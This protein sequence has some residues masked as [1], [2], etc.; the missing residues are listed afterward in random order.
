MGCCNIGGSNDSNEKL[1]VLDSDFQQASKYK[2]SRFSMKSKAKSIINIEKNACENKHIEK[3]SSNLS[4][5][6]ERMKEGNLT[7]NFD[8][9]ININSPNQTKSSLKQFS[10]L[11]SYNFDD[12]KDFLNQSKYTLNLETIN[13]SSHIKSKS[14]MYVNK[15]NYK[16]FDYNNKVSRLNEENNKGISEVG[17]IM[18]N[19]KNYNCTN[20][21]N[22]LNFKSYANSLHET[23]KNE[24][25]NR[26]N[27][28]VSPFKPDSILEVT[29]DLMA[30]GNSNYVI[31]IGERSEHTLKI[32]ERNDNVEEQ[33]VTNNI[34]FN[35][36]NNSTLNLRSKERVSS[37]N[38]YSNRSPYSNIKKVKENFDFNLDTFKNP[39]FLKSNTN[40]TKA[41]SKPN[42]SLL[43]KKDSLQESIEPQDILTI[44]SLYNTGC[45][46]NSRYMNQTIISN[47]DINS[48]KREQNKHLSSRSMN[49]NCFM[50]NPL[51][52]ISSNFQGNDSKIK[53]KRIL[54]SYNFLFQDN[55]KGS[56]DF[57]YNSY[58]DCK[59]KTVDS[60]SNIGSFTYGKVGDFQ[61]IL[62][63]KEYL[64]TDSNEK[65]KENVYDS[66]IG[67]GKE[68]NEEKSGDDGKTRVYRKNLKDNILKKVKL[69]TIGEYTESKKKENSNVLNDN[70]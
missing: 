50:E 30:T 2:G 43:I 20:S 13:N 10:Q 45:N 17:R 68:S 46:N 69:S 3:T 66:L 58:N 49:N 38:E 40:Y 4:E 27:P 23:F 21:Y 26:N 56:K 36:S 14:Q 31:N 18:A 65:G 61:S 35:T 29:S 7:F 37:R 44:N 59:N 51:N 57:Q 67:R 33:C 11:Q 54:N 42:V 41:N 28:K 47:Q 39:L 15:L 60:E 6:K 19:D 24:R 9:I 63:G 22:S 5:K 1:I 25:F 62:M 53:T 32:K 52:T 12:S 16:S 70:F 34:K 8:L 48:S 64:L 55:N